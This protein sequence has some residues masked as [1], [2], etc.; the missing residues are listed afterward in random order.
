LGAQYGDKIP[1]SLREGVVK[2]LLEAQNHLQKLQPGWRLKIFDAYRP[3]SVQKFMVDYTF[4]Q[5]LQEKGLKSEDLSEQEKE[6]LWQQVY[7]IWAIPSDNPATPPPHST[8]AAVD[9]TLVDEKGEVVD[10]GGEIDELSERSHP[11]YYLYSSTEEG[12]L[13]NARR[14][15]L[16]QVMTQAGFVRHPGEWWHFSLGDQMWAWQH[17]LEGEHNPPLTARYGRV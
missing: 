5:L 8:G 16:H 11:N 3:V 14:E 15:L 12:Y 9:L 1:Y 10:F 7:Q 13:Y 17:N 2:A 4:A 6:E